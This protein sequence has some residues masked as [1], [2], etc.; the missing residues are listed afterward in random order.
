MWASS[1][2][3]SFEGT[4]KIILNPIDDVSSGTWKIHV[5]GAGGAWPLLLLFGA[6]N[7]FFDV[8]QFLGHGG[9]EDF[10]ACFRYQDSIFDSK[11]HAFVNELHNGLN[12][13]HL[14]HLNRAAN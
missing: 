3:V 1:N 4:A 8:T 12:G 2:R 5:V 14:S 10:R 9:A 6:A 13:H 11:M 7:Q